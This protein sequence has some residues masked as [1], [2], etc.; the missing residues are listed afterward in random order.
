[1]STLL[2]LLDVGADA[3]ADGEVF[4]GQASGPAGKRAY[5]GLMAAQ[6]LAAACRTVGDDRAPTN[7]HLQFLR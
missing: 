3:A 5:G 2:R 6:S 7:M 1:M 4:T